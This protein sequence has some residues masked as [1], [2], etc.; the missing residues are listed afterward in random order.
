MTI[1]KNPGVYLNETVQYELVGAG[2]KI[3]VWI[4]KTGNEGTQTY[5]V[6]GTV[7]RKYASWE[8]VNKATTADEPGIGVYTDSTT[9]LLLKTLKDFFEEAA[10][11]STEEIGVP[12]IYVIDVGDGTSKTAWTTALTTA[13]T[14]IDAKILAIV[15]A[16]GITNYSLKDFIA[17][18][19]TAMDTEAH[20][21]GLWNA[22]TTSQSATSDSDLIALTNASTGNQV[23]RVGIAEPLLFGKTVAR[24]CCTPYY[25]EPGFLQYRSVE[26]GT[27]KKRTAAEKLALQNAGIIFNHD[28]IVNDQI[29]T[30]MNLCTA[31]SFAA[32]KRPADALFHARFNADHLLLEILE[33]LYP[34]IKANETQS[35]LVKLQVKVDAVID[36]AIEDGTMIKYNSATGEGTRLILTE[37]N[38]NPYDM[39]L[40]G[41]IQPVNS[42]IAIN[43][44]ETINTAVL[45]A[46]D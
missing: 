18:V 2:S 7:I 31:T 12:Y 24:I 28:E 1:T 11:E 3:P 41:T 34:Q 43:V 5:K 27:F 29:W 6:D 39:E 25:I 9:N 45:H 38:Y 42:T 44:K 8:D 37:S 15:G 21:F 13:M 35:S 10:I 4:G 16:E 23:S 36:A 17:G 26:P 32:T 19:K 20:T 22:F 30:R 46:S 40:V 33:A 14:M